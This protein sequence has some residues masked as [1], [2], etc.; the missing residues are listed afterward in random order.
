MN[1]LIFSPDLAPY[2]LILDAI[3]NKKCIDTSI[4]TAPPCQTSLHC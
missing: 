1:E 2:V 4:Y 3:K